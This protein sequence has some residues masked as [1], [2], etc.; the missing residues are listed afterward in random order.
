MSELLS[1]VRPSL[2]ERQHAALHNDLLEAGIRRF[3]EYGFD[4]T[5]MDQIARDAG[6]SRR[7][8]FRY[9]PTKEDIVLSG[10]LAS[11]HTVRD[12]VTAR[13]PAES[14][15]A[16]LK[17]ALLDQIA[18]KAESH[19]LAL[20]LARLIKCT[21]RLR[22]R[23]HEI[24]DAWEAAMIEGLVARNQDRAAH[25]PLAAAVAMATARV[26]FRRWLAAGGATPLRESI[27]A[28]FDELERLGV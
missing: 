11:A 28:S 22:A 24:T 7:T 2:R 23:G 14:D 16:C 21:P 17:G 4:K 12:A 25:A 19:P 27:C 13:P 10:P 9:F 6:V 18:G 5:T 20:P 8:V 26:G 1:A 15:L 3:L